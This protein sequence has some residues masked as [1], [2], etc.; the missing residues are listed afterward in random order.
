MVD[1][2][3]DGNTETARFYVW[4]EYAWHA[5]IEIWTTV[6][7]ALV[8]VL[9]WV[10]SLKCQVQ[11]L[12][13]EIFIQLN[14]KGCEL[15]FTLYPRWA[16]MITVEGKNHRRKQHALIGNMSI[17]QNTDVGEAPKWGHCT[18]SLIWAWMCHCSVLCFLARSHK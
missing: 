11:G 16:L 14:H 3:S 8:C 15:V 18:L 13:V 1:D 7:G 12:K 5:F 2:Y 10:S 9:G 4:N 17:F 6:G